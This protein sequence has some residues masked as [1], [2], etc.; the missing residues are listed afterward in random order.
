[1]HYELIS[2]KF[3]TGQTALIWYKVPP[4]LQ[5]LWLKNFILTTSRS[6][7]NTG[8]LQIDLYA[9]SKLFY[10]PKEGLSTILSPQSQALSTKSRSTSHHPSSQYCS[11]AEPSIFRTSAGLHTFRSFYRIS[12]PITTTT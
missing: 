4:H 5:D 9:T 7:S 11:N 10:S 3:G 2:S 1:M 6:G 8:I 12:C